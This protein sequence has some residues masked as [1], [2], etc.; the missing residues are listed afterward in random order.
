[1][2]QLGIF[3]ERVILE[4]IF[5]RDIFWPSGV[6]LYGMAAQV[7]VNSYSQRDYIFIN[8]CHKQSNLQIGFIL[9]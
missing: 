7:Y 6:G 3:R 1:V 5:L 9:L 8:L 2:D 4:K